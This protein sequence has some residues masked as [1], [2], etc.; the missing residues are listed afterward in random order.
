ML[1]FI[2]VLIIMIHGLIHFMGFAKAF[3]YGN[4]IQLTKEI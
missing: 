3:H 4:I 1:R 2:I